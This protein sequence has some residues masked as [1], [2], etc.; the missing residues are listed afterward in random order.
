MR[1]GH[2]VRKPDPTLPRKSAK[3]LIQGRRSLIG[4]T[5][6]GIDNLTSV[7]SPKEIAAVR[8][9]LQE[10]GAEGAVEPSVPT[11]RSMARA[12]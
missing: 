6:G 12:N 7:A 5:R 4:S 1:F 8:S 9:G 2:L 11:G 3:R 10:I